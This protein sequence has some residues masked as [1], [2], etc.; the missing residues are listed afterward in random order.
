MDSL[1]PKYESYS[2]QKCFIGHSLGTEWSKDVQSACE[3]VLPQFN[4]EPWYAAENYTPTKTLRNK[5]VELIANCRYGVYDISS[6]QDR[7]G[8]WHLPRN[9]YIEVGIAIALNRPMLLLVHNS[10]NSVSLPA[11]FEGLEIIVEFSGKNTLKKELESRLPQWFDVPP[12]RYWLNRFCIVGNKKCSFRDKHPRIEHWGNKQIHFHVTDG[13]NKSNSNFCQSDRDE[14]RGAFEE[15]F[16]PYIGN[17]QFTYLDQLIL[18]DGYQ[19]LLCSYC[20]I[21]RATAFAIYRL[22]PQTPAEVFISIGIS[23]ALEKQF[24]YEIPKV[25]LVKQERDIPSLLKGYEAIK[26]INSS[27]IEEK[28]QDFLPTVIKLVGAN[29]WRPTS[30][31]F[32]VEDSQEEDNSNR[33]FNTHKA[34]EYGLDKVNDARFEMGWDRLD[35][36]WIEAANVSRETLKNFWERSKIPEDDFIAICQ[37]VGIED[38]EEITREG[39]GHFSTLRSK[40]S[41][42]ETLTN[43]LRD[44]GIQ[45]KTNAD[46]RGSNGQRL[47]ADIVAV[48]EG[49]YDIG[50]LEN[51]EGTFDYVVDLWGVAKKYSQTEL[52]NS[53]NQKYAVNKTLAK[54]KQLN[55]KTKCPRCDSV[56][57]Q[58]YGYCQGKQN[59]KCLSCGTQFS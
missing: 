37:A 9:V 52:I 14:I 27:D 48:L 51:S 44:L 10:N 1:H 6:W 20:Q 16:S 38:W 17:L 31:P 13:L 3:E 46:V 21:V 15:G 25:I 18:N 45:V 28:I 4:L 35:Q 40:I 36:S 5:V 29:N 41:D 22:F 39:G 19:F 43:S 12:E 11:C 8:N 56:Q 57:T 59:Y 23:I 30:L 33:N 7:E 49:E 47:R 54:V 58:K 42:A 34:S 2:S 24:D 53:I 50:W 32:I 55:K 26:A